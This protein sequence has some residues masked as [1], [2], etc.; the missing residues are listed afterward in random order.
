MAERAQ[1]FADSL[2]ESIQ[3][4]AG[5]S[6]FSEENLR[7]TGQDPWQTLGGEAEQTEGVGSEE[8]ISEIRVQIAPVESI[9]IEPVQGNAE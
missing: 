5:S 7:I 8:P 1:W 3:E 9:A 6:L 4:A 2:N